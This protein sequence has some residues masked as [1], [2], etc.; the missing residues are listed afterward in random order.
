VAG[1]DPR[2]RGL[3]AFNSRGRSRAQPAHSLTRLETVRSPVVPEAIP[4]RVSPRLSGVSVALLYTTFSYLSSGVYA[5]GSN[6]KATSSTFSL[7][8]LV[9]SE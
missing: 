2:L 9:N 6:T 1:A 3:F 5:G 8:A 4:M 7:R